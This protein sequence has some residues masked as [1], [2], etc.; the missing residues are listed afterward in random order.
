MKIPNKMKYIKIENFGPAEGLKLSE[1]FIPHINENEVLIKV[2]ASG[3]NRPDVLQRL[4]LYSPPPD[5]SLIPGLEVSGKIVRVGKKVKKFKV[6]DK[7]CALV[8]GGGYAE[9]CKAHESHILSIPKGL[10]YIEAA[11]IP[12]TYFTVWAKLFDIA[13]IKKNQTLLVHGGSSGIGTTAIQL[14]KVIGCDVITTVADKKE[15][16]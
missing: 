6:N 14:A 5:A 4:G 15:Q 11:G 16:V 2:Y 3:V 12:E 13:K 8:H 7:V 1:T 9:Y 10:N